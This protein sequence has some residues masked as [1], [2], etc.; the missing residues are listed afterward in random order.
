MAAA[1]GPP[2][3]RDAEVVVAILQ[4]MG[5]ERFEPRVLHQLMEFIHRY[6]AEVFQDGADFAEHS[7]RGG[8]IE[9]EDVQLAVRLKAAASQT[10]APELIRWLAYA[11]N[12]EQLPEQAQAGIKLPK[13][14]LCLLHPNYQLEPS[15]AALEKFAL[16]SS[17]APRPG[18][19][20]VPV[21]QVRL[22]GEG[23]GEA[24]KEEDGMWEE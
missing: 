10:S 11:R 19:S 9:C 20:S 24:P 1:S 7:G 14:H 16:E 17:L 5:V 6:C 18:V 21:Q 3:P 22:S 23:A 2:L 12:K 15:D 8:A 4:S 13:E